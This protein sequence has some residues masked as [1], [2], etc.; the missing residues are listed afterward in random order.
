[1]SDKISHLVHD[2]L[3]GI[4][5]I[6]KSETVVGDPQQA[7][8]AMIIPVHRMKVAF[9]VGSAKAGAQGGRAGAESGG[10]A[11]GGAIEL[12]PIAAIAVG[13]DGMPRILTVEAEPEGAWAN[14]L[15][16]APD[17][18]ARVVSALGDRVTTEVKQRVLAAGEAKIERQLSA[19]SEE[20]ETTEKARLR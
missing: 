17:L 12:D 10:M 11:A 4:H 19:K 14:L 8:E 20:A 5:G 16:E 1:M 9:G 6:A 2:L 18:L 3:D 15:Q 7:G 13:K